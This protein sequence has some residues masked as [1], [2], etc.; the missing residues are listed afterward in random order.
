MA[1]MMY[2]SIIYIM[3]IWC[4]CVCISAVSCRQSTA[5]YSLLGFFKPGIPLI[6]PW[7][8]VKQNYFKIISAFVN[9]RLK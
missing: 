2:I 1:T 7:L 5:I 6:M 3:W 4:V 8:H 9:V